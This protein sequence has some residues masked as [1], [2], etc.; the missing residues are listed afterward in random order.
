MKINE[1]EA[2]VGITKKN[3][4]F[5]EEQGLLSPRRNSENGYREY[6]PHEVEQ[7]QQ[8]KLLRKL[9]VPLEEIRQ[10]QSG[11][12]T[13]G[14]GIRR[15]LVTLERE[16]KNL[17]QSIELCQTLKDRE[18][19]L[20]NLDAGTLLQHMEALE[21]EG[22]TF[23]N[24]Q[25]SDAR[26]IRYIAP[27]VVAILT[28]LLMSGLIALLIWAFAV[29]SEAPPLLFGIVLMAIPAIVILGVLLALIQRFREIGKGEIDDAKQ[30]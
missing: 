16:K 23:L 15:H 25:I 17:E 4:R 3:I 5:Y 20:E 22:T 24:K 6:G 18:E 13:L 10:M 11:A 2:K 8:I 12:H 26:R 29:E 19:R 14:D 30:Y 1:V 7:L 27:I 21:R 9:G 28:I